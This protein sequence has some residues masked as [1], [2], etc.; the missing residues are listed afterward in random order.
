MDN[1]AIDNERKVIYELLEQRR[2]ND[3]FDAI[4]SLIDSTNMGNLRDEIDQVRVSYGFMLQYLSKGILDPHR[5]Q[6]L[7]HIIDSLYSI[8]DRCSIEAKAATSSE[9]FF[10]RRREL[11]G[12]PLQ[13][14]I[15][16][17]KE[18]L[19]KQQLLQSVPN[20]QQNAIALRHILKECEQLETSIFNKVWCTFPTSHDESQLI[21]N[22][23]ND[24][25]TPIHVQCL[26]LS[27]LFL[28]LI[29]LFD[30]TKLALVAQAYTNS[31]NVQVQIRAFIYAILS[32]YVYNKR[33]TH[34]PQVKACL[35]AM[36]LKPTFAQDMSTLQFLLA[37]SRNTDNITR[38]VRE[39]I[40]PDI[41]NMS[42]DIVRKIKD[43]NAPVDLT[44]FEA[45]PEWQD[46]L[47]DSGIAKKME[48]FNEM[49]LEGN[50]VYIGAFSRLKSFP[51]F[52]TLSNWFLPY[53]ASNSLI[54]D[55]FG[56][57]PNA[58]GELVDDAPLCNSDKYSFCL[59]IS[60]I[61]ESQRD[62]MFAQVKEQHNEMKELKNSELPHDKK[63]RE[64]AANSH[65]QDL[66]RF[67][68]LFSRRREFRPLFD[69]DMDMTQ[70]PL[71]EEHTH[72]HV[73]LSI[74][75]EFYFK[76]NFH[77]DAIKYYDHLLNNS[78]KV[79]PIVFQKIG[80]CYQNLGNMREAIRQYKRYLLAHD[81]DLW[82]LKHL[83][84]CY[85]AMNRYDKALDY[86]K[87]VELLQPQ[88]VTTTLNIGHCLLENGNV[89]E[90]LKYYYK[91]DFIDGANHRAWRP[92]AWCSFLTGNDE[93][94]LSYYDKIIAHDKATAQDY[95]NRGHVLLCSNNIPEAIE[96]YRNALAHENSMTTFRDAFYSDAS[97]LENRGIMR[98]DM[99]L[100]IDVLPI[101]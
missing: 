27:A 85:R 21:N 28:G 72:K 92:I 59:S 30:D 83:A 71:F 87:K 10:A 82:T 67:F 76:N 69:L 23:L 15:V 62:I 16:Q 89:E 7:Q 36:V 31:D 77:E 44:D 42:P 79:D 66:Y 64:R 25:S 90:A 65:L 54:L 73:T 34:T 35:E 26:V 6:V 33:A 52:H 68:K 4:I 47:E 32:V 75:A 57:N 84:G 13:S 60:S 88:S 29:V 17:W 58:M 78:D 55:T 93:R 45:N 98:D 96:S 100:I 80:F 53:H 40:M 19:H 9:V 18:T 41:L 91:A 95:M 22:L 2:I 38:R 5:Q 51:F 1:R 50:D 8:T 39:D 70:L 61:P 74:I 37:R 12:T 14:L 56:S 99:A 11:E 86:Y 20:E 97:Q 63:V 94:A 101:K 81:G 43:K 49:Q 46:M 24:P 3:A 48:Q